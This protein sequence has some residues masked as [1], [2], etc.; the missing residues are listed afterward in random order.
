[1]KYEITDISK[2]QSVAAKSA[3]NFERSSH[4]VIMSAGGDK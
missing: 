1:M 4:E 3:I 2:A